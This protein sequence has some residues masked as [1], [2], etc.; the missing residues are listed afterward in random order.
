MSS[1]LATPVPD[2]LFDEMNHL[3]M[4]EKIPVEVALLHVV[5]L[6]VDAR[7]PGGL[8][9]ACRRVLEAIEKHLVDLFVTTD[10]ITHSPESTSRFLNPPPEL[11]YRWRALGEIVEK[12]L[13]HLR[14]R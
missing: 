13:T 10:W 8:V 2:S 5:L 14:H 3:L 11:M 6:S 7:D 4:D 1:H 12:L 9:P